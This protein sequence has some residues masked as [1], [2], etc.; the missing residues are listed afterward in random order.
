MALYSNESLA[1]RMLHA[2]NPTAGDIVAKKIRNAVQPLLLLDEVQADHDALGCIDD[3]VTI[4]ALLGGRG[5]P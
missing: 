5:T 2:A 4:A 3:L 1:A